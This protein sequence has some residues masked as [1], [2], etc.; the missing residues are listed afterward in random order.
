MDA[1]IVSLATA[2]PPRYATQREAWEFLQSHF[3]MSD[4]E[5]ELYRRLLL[6]GP[7]EGRHVGVRHDQQAADLS[8]DALHER[9]IHF[10]TLTGSRA[11]AEAL[12]AAGLAAADVGALVVSTCTGY[13]C[14]GL[15]SYI[16]ESL[17]L[18]EQVGVLD[19][20]GMGCG[21]A[22]PNL[23]A[24][25]GLLAAGRC[26][27]VL[28]AAVEVCSAT[29]FMGSDP[30]LIVS[31]SIFGDGAA[32]AV[33]AAGGQRGLQLVDFQAILWPRYREDLRY[34]QEG[35]RLRN[36]LSRRVPVIAARAA[37]RAVDELLGR[38]GLSAAEVRLWAVHP[39]GSAVLDEVADK[40]RL[41]P[42]AL[43]YSRAILRQYGN[44]SSPSVLFVLRRML[45]QAR[46]AR[47]EPI[48]LVAVGAGFSAYAALLRAQEPPA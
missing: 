1:A 4:G 5:R 26:K 39:G 23:Q 10:G 2:N 19:L 18:G 48:V 31:N 30:G 33:V 17:G 27:T 34:R 41:P 42:E 28:S 47:G 3:A 44:M 40:L 6:D 22:I 32:A 8:P 37:A 13:A 29:M 35:G 7:V 11:C 43:D 12:A 15:S 36:T 24:A 45:D 46:P 16:A 25:A 21:A 38:A 20:A 14:P 9:F